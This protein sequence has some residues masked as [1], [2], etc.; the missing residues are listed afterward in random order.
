MSTRTFTYP[1]FLLLSLQPMMFANAQ[2]G[3]EVGNGKDKP[4][5]KIICIPELLQTN[6][7]LILCDP[8]NSNKNGHVIISYP[9]PYDGDEPNNG[10]VIIS[11]PVSGQANSASC[12]CKRWTRKT[13]RFWLRFRC[14]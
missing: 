4:G 5:L 14:P 2:G 7:R 12:C 9:A 10:H 1:L 8:G 3:Q 13:S 11:Y 6:G